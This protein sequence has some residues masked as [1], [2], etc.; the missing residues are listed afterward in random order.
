MNISILGVLPWQELDQIGANE[1]R[2]YIA[3]TLLQRTFGTWWGM[4]GTFLIMWTAFA[5]VFSLM[6]GYSRVRMPRRRMETFSA[7]M[8]SCIPKII[9]LT[10]P[11]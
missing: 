8:R 1:A 5:S 4:F 2:Y 11:C 10:A 3:S 6:L 9:S 7:P